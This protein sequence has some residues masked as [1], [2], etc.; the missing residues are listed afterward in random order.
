MILD[1]IE[2]YK[3]YC[4]NPA[5]EKAFAFI[6]DYIAD[7]KP[8]GRYDIDGDNVFA[9]VSSY[10]TKLSGDMEAHDKYIDI[11]FLDGECEKIEYV[12]REN[13]TV[14]IPYVDDIVFFEDAPNQSALVLTKGTFCVLYP[15]DAHKPGQ[16]VGNPVLV[17]KIVVKIK[18]DCI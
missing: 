2:N 3:L 9:M 7:P 1:R 4:T 8:V 6:N 18:M 5:F 13:L 11:Q 12:Y 17:N 14:K 15:W 10:D 16:A